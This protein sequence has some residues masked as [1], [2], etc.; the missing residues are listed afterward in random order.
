MLHIYISS[1]I[2]PLT[3][4][5][6]LAQMHRTV[7]WTFWYLTCITSMVAVTNA[8]AICFIAYTMP[9]TTYTGI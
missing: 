3:I 4:T 9:R 7:I 5:I 1:Y 6:A 8:R 2:L